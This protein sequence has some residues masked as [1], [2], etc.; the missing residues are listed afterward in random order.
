MREAFADVWRYPDEAQEGLT[1]AIAR[2]HS[3]STEQ[4]LLGDGSSEILKL[5]AAAFIGPKRKLVLAAP[6]FEAIAT[7]AHAA[8]SEVVSLP[9]D[10]NYRHDVAAMAA[11]E[12][13]GLVYICN[14]NNPTASITPHEAMKRLLR[15]VPPSTTI[16]VDEACHHYAGSA[17][18]ESVIPLIASTPNLAVARTFSKIYGPEYILGM[19]GTGGSTMLT[20]EDQS[21]TV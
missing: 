1:D 4:I 3:V 18:Y 2:S 10:S 11:V 7:Y 19:Q 9:L 17:E 8:G 16:L 21:T 12:G 6:T 5:A 13:A 15:I 20:S 14:P